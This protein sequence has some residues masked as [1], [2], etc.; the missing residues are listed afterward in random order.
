[1]AYNR[2]ER[3]VACERESHF[4]NSGCGM[5]H[6]HQSALHIFSAA[7]DDPLRIERGRVAISDRDRV[8]VPVE[9]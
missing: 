1:M 5:R 8:N 6:R 3:E 9:H 4:I 2:G 7:S